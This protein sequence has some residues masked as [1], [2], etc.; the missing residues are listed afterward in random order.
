MPHG[1]VALLNYKWCTYRK[2]YEDIYWLGIWNLSHDPPGLS[3]DRR[4]L[5]YP[6]C[7][8]WRHIYF[9]QRENVV[10][11]WWHDPHCLSGSL[12]LDRAAAKKAFF[13]FTKWNQ[14]TRLQ[15]CRFC[16][17]LLLNTAP[18]RS[19]TKTVNTFSPPLLH[20]GECSVFANWTVL[21]REGRGNRAWFTLSLNQP[22]F[23]GTHT[24]T[25]THS[26]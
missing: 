8:L 19:L 24:R 12:N 18:K 4:R 13:F 3:H 11:D 26:W 22:H 10:I 17:L 15:N 16:A 23:V 7:S 2:R 25:H 14:C 5:P 20:S 1:H 6:C 9:I 21:V